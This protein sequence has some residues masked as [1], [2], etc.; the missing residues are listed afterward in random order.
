MP[1]RE[2]YLDS[3]KYQVRAW[4]WDRP[5]NIVAEITALNRIRRAK[6]A[7]RTHLNTTFL[8]AGND[9]V[10]VFMKATP[11]RSNV[12]VVAVSLRPGPGAGDRL[13]VPVLA[14]AGRR[15]R[16]VRGRGPVDRRASRP[17]ATS[18]SVRLDPARPYAIWRVTRRITV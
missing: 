7:L 12:L 11:D 6:P 5:G 16:R 13:G 3:E 1:G 8:P 15:E 9:V 4:D 10:S 14:V 17:G 18:T 2:E